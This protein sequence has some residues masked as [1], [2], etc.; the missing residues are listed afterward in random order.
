[1]ALELKSVV[2]GAFQENEVKQITALPAEEEPL[3]LIPVGR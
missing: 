1:V 3:Y 2:I